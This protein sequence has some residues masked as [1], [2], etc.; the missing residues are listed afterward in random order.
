MYNNNHPKQLAAAAA[1]AA[2]S[3]DGAKPAAIGETP[4]EVINAR[5]VNIK[6]PTSSDSITKGGRKKKEDHKFP[7]EPRII[8]V[9]KKP[10]TYVD[11]SYRDFS[12]VPADVDYEAPNQIQEMNFPLKLHDILSNE[13]HFNFITWMPHGRSFRIDVPVLFE[14]EVCEKYYNHKRYSSFLRQLNTHGFKHLTKGQDRN[15]YYHEV[16]CFYTRNDQ[17]NVS[18]LSL[19]HNV[20]FFLCVS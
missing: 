19:T 13:A 7:V 9:I 2:L 12:S 4:T 8:Q 1:L 14:K 17:Y 16:S 5:H 6:N 3:D 18:I 20:F 10:K 15:S 11:H